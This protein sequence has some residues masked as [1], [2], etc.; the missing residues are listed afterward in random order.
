MYSMMRGVDREMNMDIYPKL[1]YPEIY[2]LEGGY[3]EFY[4][5]HREHCSG[6]YISK[7]DAGEK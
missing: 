1:F 2:V 7:S 5:K 4:G 6:G 3:Q